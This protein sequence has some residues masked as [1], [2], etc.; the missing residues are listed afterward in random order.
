MLSHD[1]VL[2][3]WGHRALGCGGWQHRSTRGIWTQQ[4]GPQ[5]SDS[6]LAWA[7]CVAR[8]W[9]AVSCGCQDRRKL[10]GKALK[11]THQQVKL[12]N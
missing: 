3:P 1:V 2:S 12:C 4:V 5:A 8:E 10:A 6:P 7:C 11:G 9:E